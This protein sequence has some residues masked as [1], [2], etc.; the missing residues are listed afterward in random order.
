[1]T[2]PNEHLPALA[3]RMEPRRFD[4]L[5][6]GGTGFVGRSVCEKLVER[7][8]GA[9]GRIAVPT[10]RASRARH[11]QMLPTVELIEADVHDEARLAR[12]VAGRDAVINLVAIL[13]GSQ[14]DFQRVH[15]DLP[16]KLARACNQAK[17][18]RVVHVSAIGAADNA[19][20]RYLRT[21][22]AGEAALK[23]AGLELTLL[24][25]SVVFGEHDSFLNLFAAL[26]AAFPLLPLAGAQARFQPVWVEDLAAA[27]VHCLDDDTTIGQT[28]EIA[29]PRVLT[30]KEIAQLAGRWSGHER[31]I[32]ALP[33]PLGRLQAAMMEMLPGVPLMSRDNIDSM[34]TPNVAGGHCPGLEQLGIVASSLESVAP[35][36]LGHA[37]GPGRLDPWRAG[38]GRS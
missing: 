6:L 1:M 2:R 18:R 34:R 37:R 15:V 10:R 27:I 8:G 7:S 9:S 11:I 33:L 31:P 22:A 17:V 20:S 24:R 19:P 32:V 16:A 13:H 12:L 3:T 23:S 5:V 30:L 4:V 36:Y 28:F 14:A 29:G 21:K 25:P 35:G 38:A 26:Q